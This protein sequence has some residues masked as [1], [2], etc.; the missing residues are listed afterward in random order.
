MAIHSDF[1]RLVRF[2]FSTQKGN[3]HEHH[4][5]VGWCDGAP[6]KPPVPGG[7]W[8]IVGQGPLRLQ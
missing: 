1:T 4:Q 6:G 5:V 2:N 3:D 8:I 7:P